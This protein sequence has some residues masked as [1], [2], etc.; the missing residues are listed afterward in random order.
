MENDQVKT[1]INTDDMRE[2]F[3]LAGAMQSSAEIANREPQLAVTNSQQQIFFAGPKCGQIQL[4]RA[5]IYNTNT[6]QLLA[7]V[8]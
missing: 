5:H 6:N 8:R 7:F 3:C 4:K 2:R 1:N